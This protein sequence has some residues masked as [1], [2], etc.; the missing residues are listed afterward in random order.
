MCNTVAKQEC[1]SW[2]HT[3][4]FDFL[5]LLSHDFLT[6][7]ISRQSTHHPSLFFFSLSYCERTR[8]ERWFEEE[9]R[10]LGVTLPIFEC[11]KKE[12]FAK[13]LFF[14]PLALFSST[15]QDSSSS[16]ST[17]LLLSFWRI[18]STVDRRALVSEKRQTQKRVIPTYPLR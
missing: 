2:G 16:F 6:R 3:P 14:L 13:T 15:R 17:F 9:R 4:L 5:L 10:L 1:F 7:P 12:T 18:G 8:N 11:K